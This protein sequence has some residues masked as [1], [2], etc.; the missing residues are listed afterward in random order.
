MDLTPWNMCKSLNPAFEECQCFLRIHD[1][2]RHSLS[3]VQ[4]GAQVASPVTE[5]SD[6]P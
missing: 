6:V 1:N 4:R 5:A 2:S 3:V